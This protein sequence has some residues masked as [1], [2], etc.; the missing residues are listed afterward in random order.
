MWLFCR[1]LSSWRTS[2]CSTPMKRMHCLATMISASSRTPGTLWMSTERWARPSWT[3]NLVISFFVCLSNV[4]CLKKSFYCSHRVINNIV[5]SSVEAFFSSHFPQVETPGDK[6]TTTDSWV[7]AYTDS[8][9]SG[10][11]AAC[12]LLSWLALSR[13]A[14]PY[15]TCCVLEV[16]G[17]GWGGGGDGDGC[18][19]LVTLSGGLH[20]AQSHVSQIQAG[21]FLVHRILERS[22]SWWEYNRV[23]VGDGVSWLG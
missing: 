10:Q 8:Q 6:K 18:N 15:Y 14:S 7:T 1:Q 5:L 22:G 19:R 23:I 13:V 16:E 20:W 11:L 9:I 12:R 17:L 3:A 2:P 4:R 21:I